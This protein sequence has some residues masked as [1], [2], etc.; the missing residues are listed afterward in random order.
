MYDPVSLSRAETI[1]STEVTLP[2]VLPKDSTV[3][4]TC[5]NLVATPPNVHRML[6]AGRPVEVQEILIESVSLIVTI[7]GPSAVVE[8]ATRGNTNLV[9]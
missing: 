2:G 7:A 3:V 6:G 5:S 9:S 4:S 1:C 8:G